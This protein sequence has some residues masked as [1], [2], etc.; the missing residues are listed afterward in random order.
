[1]ERTEVEEGSLRA[2]TDR[3]S[4]KI[5]DDVFRLL[6]SGTHA[7]LRIQNRTNSLHGFVGSG[8]AVVQ[9]KSIFS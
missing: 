4:D 1:M 5:G 8:D 6:Q 3:L 7:R 2:L 9:W